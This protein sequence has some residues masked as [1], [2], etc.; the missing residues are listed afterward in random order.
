MTLPESYWE[1]KIWTDDLKTTL[2]TTTPIHLE[3]RVSRDKKC[4]EPYTYEID[5]FLSDQTANAIAMG[6]YFELKASL[7]STKVLWCS[8]YIHRLSR[9]DD[10]SNTF[11]LEC[12]SAMD[13]LNDIRTLG[14]FHTEPAL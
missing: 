1:L 7:T 13:A 12:V 2:I 5:C 9:T 10:A 4:N 14:N 11:T 8:G 3:Q 6:Y